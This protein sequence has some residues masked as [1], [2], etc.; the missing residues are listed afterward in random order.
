MAALRWGILGT[1]GIAHSQAADLIGNGFTLTAVGSRTQGSADAF[2]AEFGIPTAHG[3]YEAL[4]ADPEVDV[5]YVSTPH[6]FHAENAL[7]ALDAG[8]HVLLEKPFTVNAAEAAA[9]V[10][11]ATKNNVVVLEA[12]WARFLPHMVRIREIIAAGTIG[13]VRTLIADHDRLLPKDPAHRINNP[14]LGGGALLDLG[15]YP[16]SF[17]SDLFGA[18]S[19]V[20]ANSSPTATGVDRQT[21]IILGYA[22]G[23]QAVLHVSLDTEGPNRAAIMGTEG[24]IEIDRVWYSP[25]SFTV[26]DS[27]GEVVEKY[28]SEVS[29][30]GMQYQAWELERLVEAGLPAGDILPPS[31]SVAIMETLDEIR[32]QIGLVY[33]G[34]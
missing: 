32:R 10:E 1:G 5:I 4:V 14:E 25:T 16:V 19:T 28:S 15:I 34:E 26:F 23:Q 31:E 13:E 11:H 29:P 12:M 18:P 21:A 22:D 2:A 9:V 8:K 30:R 20:Q 27:E 3:S 7:L 24:W 6:P 17:A 33:P